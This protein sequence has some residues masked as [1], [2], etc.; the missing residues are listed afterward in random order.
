MAGTR[1]HPAAPDQRDLRAGCPGAISAT[2]DVDDGRRSSCR[3]G[4]C[5]NTAAGASAV[6]AGTAEDA[7]VAVDGDGRASFTGAAAAERVHVGGVKIQGG[8]LKWTRFSRDSMI[9]QGDK[10]FF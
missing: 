1:L 8:G 9:L 3:S 5:H 4:C 10:V 6:A 7:K 2:V